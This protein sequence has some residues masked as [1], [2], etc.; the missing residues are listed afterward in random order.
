[1]KSGN[2]HRA[3]HIFD[4]SLVMGIENLAFTDAH[5]TLSFAPVA[6]DAVF[7]ILVPAS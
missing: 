3:L 5:W 2:F 1:M 4:L 6:T 7:A